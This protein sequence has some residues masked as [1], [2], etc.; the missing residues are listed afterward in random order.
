MESSETD[1]VCKIINQFVWCK[2]PE[3]VR[4]R[5]SQV[6][7]RMITSSFVIWYFPTFINL[8]CFHTKLIGVIILSTVDT[9]HMPDLL[10]PSLLAWRWR[11]P[12][13]RRAAASYR[14]PHPSMCPARRGARRWR[15]RHGRLEGKDNG[16]DTVDCSATG[17]EFNLPRHPPL[18]EALNSTK[19]ATSW[20]A[21]HIQGQCTSINTPLH[22]RC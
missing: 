2:F 15:R 12:R 13:K 17:E 21:L 8:S 1:K 3:L 4:N 19:N 14:H 18:A 11:G 6:K 7:N 22:I 9:F 16:D 20:I 10:L 5:D